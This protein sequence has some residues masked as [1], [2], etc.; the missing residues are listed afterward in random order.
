MNVN[1]MIVLDPKLRRT[2]F[3]LDEACAKRMQ[4]ELAPGKTVELVLWPVDNFNQKSYGPPETVQVKCS[5]EAPYA[6]LRAS[7]YHCRT[8]DFGDHYFDYQVTSLRWSPERLR[9]ETLAHESTGD[10]STPSSA[11]SEP[12]GV[13][14]VR[15]AYQR[16]VYA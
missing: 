5:W 9:R 15:R 6:A 16:A 2:E 3:R 14:V 12:D 1:E 4:T 7:S 11:Y 13:L 10:L 8:Q